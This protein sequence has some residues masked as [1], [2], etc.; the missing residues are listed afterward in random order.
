MY[1][2]PRI[3]ASRMSLQVFHKLGIIRST[4]NNV[5]DECDFFQL[6]LGESES[7]RSDTFQLFLQLFQDN[8]NRSLFIPDGIT[9]LYLP[10]K[11]ASQ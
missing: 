8:S 6:T 7:M 1:G 9:V 2:I 3:V 4:V 11:Q 10:V 5:M